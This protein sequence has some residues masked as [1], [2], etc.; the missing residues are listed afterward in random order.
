MNQV[1]TQDVG[2]KFETLCVLPNTWD[3]TPREYIENR[4]HEI[5]SNHAQYCSVVKTG[6]GSTIMVL[7]GEVDA[8]RDF[9]KVPKHS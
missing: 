3:E 5:V 1:L 7:G 2:Y 9:P 6:I 4:E 8:G